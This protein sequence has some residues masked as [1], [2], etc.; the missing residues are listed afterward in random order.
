MLNLLN[1]QQ[2]PDSKLKDLLKSEK[3]EEQQ[4]QYQIVL[5]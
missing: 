5:N 2:L 1:P 4:Q 3:Q